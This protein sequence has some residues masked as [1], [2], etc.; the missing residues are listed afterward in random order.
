MAIRP[1]MLSTIVRNSSSLARSRSSACLRSLISV[2]RLYQRKIEPSGPC[3]RRPRGY[4]TSDTR[5]RPGE[6]GILDER[7]A[8][9]HRMYP[10]LLHA[11]ADRLDDDRAPARELLKR[12]AEVVEHSAVGEIDLAGRCCR[13]DQR[14]NGVENQPKVVLGGPREACRAWK[15]SSM[16]TLVPHHSVIVLTHHEAA[17]RGTS[18]TGD[19]PSA[20]SRRASIRLARRRRA[21]SANTRSSGEVILDERGRSIPIRAPDPL[22]GRCSPATAG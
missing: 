2:S 19:R 16:S 15:M 9:R 14:R 8:R 13:A 6:S 22:T 20:R 21:G 17:Q 11:S 12:E 5:R 3:D 1:G 10:G 7:L 18:T 4:E